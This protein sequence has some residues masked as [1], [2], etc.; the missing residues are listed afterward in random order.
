MK[1]ITLSMMLMIL[2]ASFSI[3]AQTKIGISAGASFANVDIKS[4]GFSVSPKLKP[5]I[6]AGI[7]AVASLSSHFSFQPALNF[8]QKGYKMKDDYGTEKVTLNYIEL[9][10]NFVFRGKMNEG[11]FIGAGPSF[12]YGISGNEKYQYADHSMPDENYKI[13]FGS[14]SDKAK[15]FDFGANAI[16]GYQFKGGFMLAANYSLSLSKFNN[17]DGSGDNGSIKNRY[18]TIKIGYVFGGKKHK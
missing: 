17:D 11:F 9:P 10:L 14:G 12:A 15:P 2:L 18:F 4:G 1:S 13:K 3:S 6:T 5:G 7:H 8:V 16:A